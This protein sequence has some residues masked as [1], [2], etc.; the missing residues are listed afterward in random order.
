[1]RNSVDSAPASK[2]APVVEEGITFSWRRNLF[3]YIAVTGALAPALVF[4]GW[5]RHGGLRLLT[6]AEFVFAM[7]VAFAIDS[8]RRWRKAR[9][10]E[11]TAGSARLSL[12]GLLILISGLTL[13][14]GLIAAE[15]QVYQRFRDEV[16]QLQTNVVKLLGPD[17]EFGSLTDGSITLLICDRSFDDDRFAKVARLISDW[18]PDAEISQVIFSSGPA[19]NDTPPA[20]SGVTDRSVELLLGWRELKWLSVDGSAISAEGRQKLLTLAQ[21]DEISRQGLMH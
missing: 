16:H 3:L 4:V 17:G 2:A 15:Y 10:P 1:M 5:Y 7:T 8:R 12:G 13:F 6:L 21:L 19:T 14:F 18:K 20:W 11:M 9:R